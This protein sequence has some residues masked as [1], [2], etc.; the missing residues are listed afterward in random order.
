ML[1]KLLF[2][3]IYSIYWGL[4]AQ[5]YCSDPLLFLEV[6]S[7]WNLEKVPY[8]FDCPDFNNDERNY[9]LYMGIPD[10][11]LWGEFPKRPVILATPG[12]A[13][14]NTACGPFVCP[15]A[16]AISGQFSQYGYITVSVEYRQ[17]IGDFNFCLTP[18]EE[19]F[20]THW[21]AVQ[22]LRT[23]VQFV[24]DNADQYGFD[25]DNIFLFANSAGGIASLHS[26]FV[27]E[28]QEL[29]ETKAG[30]QDAVSDLG[31]LPERIEVQA[32]MTIA[33]G[34]YSLDLIDETEETPLF[35]AHGMCDSVAAYQSGP[36][37]GC[38]ALPTINGSYEIAA[39]AAQ[40]NIPVSFHAVDKLGHAWP[41]ET[42]DSAAVLMRHWLKEQIL[43][44]E[45]ETESHY[46]LSDQKE[47][48][49]KDWNPIALG[50][51]EQVHEI[52]LWFFDAA[53]SSLRLRTGMTEGAVYLYD[54]QGREIA[55]W[56]ARQNQLSLRNSINKGV[57]LL[58]EEGKAHAQRILIQD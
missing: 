48:G 28:E 49:P 58:F 55:Q 8:C 32:C 50:L 29:Y 4:S 5:N 14:G 35:L 11:N 24:H 42:G 18:Q 9:H 37:L 51:T 53:T 56:P 26:V 41:Q 31:P 45:P 34:I 36:M 2:V 25:A 13:F 21:R 7:T 17:D 16:N 3:L 19:V 27:E 1:K 6:S 44:G 33:T 15:F 40:E 22:D 23:A 10:D 54:L 20:R 38:P 39:K 47:C 57:F 52:D 12:Y 46:Y 43:C 30:L